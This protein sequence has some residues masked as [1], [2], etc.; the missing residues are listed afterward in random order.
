VREVTTAL[1]SRCYD[2]SRSKDF[3]AKLTSTTTPQTPAAF[4]AFLS[5]LDSIDE[6]ETLTMPATA[7]VKRFENDVGWNPI[8]SDFND[9]DHPALAQ[10]RQQSLSSLPSSHHADDDVAARL[11][12][13]LDRPLEDLIDIVVPTIRNVSFLEH[14]KP[15]VVNC[16]IIIIQDGDPDVDIFIPS[17]VK[18]ELYNR[19][20]IERLLGDDAWIISQRDASIRNFGFLVSD[21]KFVYTLDDDCLPATTSD[22]RVVN[23]VAEHLYNLLTPSTPDFFNTVYDP[24]RPGAD[25]VRG[26]P[27]SRRGGVPTA[28]S[29]GLW[30]NAYDYDAPTQLL[31]VKERNTRY[32]D[33]TLTVPKGALYPLCSMNVAFNKHFD[34]P[35]LHAGADGG[36]A[37]VGTVRRHVRRLG[38]KSCRGSSQRRSEERSPVHLPQQGVQPVPESEEG[39]HG[40]FLAGGSH[41]FLRERETL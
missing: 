17:W 15:F 23:A 25:F 10:L 16:T 20:D 29:H 3:A 39:V 36:R 11:A 14:W 30:L 6:S 38:L 27:Y 32:V 40:T 41:L 4:K 28:V 34:R 33:A 13:L 37:A 1:L 31:K 9:P 35:R 18:F 2:R 12:S 22:G 24:F 26:Y 21:K 19:R 5:S 7:A 8:T